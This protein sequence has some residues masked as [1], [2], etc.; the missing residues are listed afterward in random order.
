MNETIRAW[1]KSKTGWEG[2]L[3]S[4]KWKVVTV[5]FPSPRGRVRV[6]ANFN[7]KWKVF[8]ENNKFSSYFTYIKHFFICLGDVLQIDLKI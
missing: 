5:L 2:D 4:G 7:G 8:T 1:S 3:F 6:G